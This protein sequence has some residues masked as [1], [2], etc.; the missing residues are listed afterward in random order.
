MKTWTVSGGVGY[1]F[2][3]IKQGNT[4]EYEIFNS[5]S[6]FFSSCEKEN[7]D[8]KNILDKFINEYFLSKD[9]NLEQVKD[10]MVLEYN[11]KYNSL[12]GKRKQI[13]DDY[14]KSSISQIR[15]VLVTDI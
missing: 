12:N 5:I 1:A 3:G 13:H 4:E 2:I 6:K 10:Y 9:F 8:S 15:E 11:Q 14:I 7:K